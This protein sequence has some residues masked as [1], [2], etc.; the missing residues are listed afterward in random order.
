LSDGPEM[1]RRE[2]ATDTVGQP[3]V[4]FLLFA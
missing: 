4:V 1:F 2:V 3:M